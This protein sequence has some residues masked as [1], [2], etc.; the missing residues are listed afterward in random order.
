MLVILWSHFLEGETVTEIL[1]N[2]APEWL[3]VEFS[4]IGD[5][6][7]EGIA[8]VESDVSALFV[9]EQNEAGIWQLKVADGAE[10][11]AQTTSEISLRF[12]ITKCRWFDQHQRANL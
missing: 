2:L 7:I 11:E 10:F 1:E 5:A 12:Q 4:P 6:D 9:V 3:W 8:L